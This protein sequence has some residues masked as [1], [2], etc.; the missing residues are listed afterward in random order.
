MSYAGNQVLAGNLYLPNGSLSATGQTE[1]WGSL[2]VGA[3]SIPGELTVHYDEAILTL[4]SCDQP[5]ASPGC[6][7]C[8]G[9]AN[10]APAC[11]DGA[12]VRCTQDSDCCAPLKCAT[13]S[14]YCVASVK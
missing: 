9:C 8:H 13:A 6:N 7:D 14:G 12:C 4:P 10:P 3:I 5:P 1:V 11:V 2:F